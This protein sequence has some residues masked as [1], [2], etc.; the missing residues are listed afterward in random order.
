LVHIEGNWLVRRLAP[1]C[2]RIAY[3]DWPLERDEIVLLE[4]MGF[5]TGNIHLGP[6]VKAGVLAD[7][8]K[9]RPKKWLR[10]AA[11]RMADF[12]EEEAGEFRG[13]C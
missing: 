11:E 13:N 1:H 4:A 10:K 7:D 12:V 5:E 9:S 2:T 6:K 8:L 3:E